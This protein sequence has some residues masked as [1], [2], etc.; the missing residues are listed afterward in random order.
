[1][2]KILIYSDHHAHPHKDGNE[3]LPSGRSSRLQD[4]LDVL[5]EIH[6]VALDQA[7][8]V[9]FGGDLFHTRKRVD[10]DAFN[11]VVKRVEDSA[12]YQPY[13]MLVGNH[14]QYTK[15][16]SIH[17]L[18]SFDGV[19][20]ID[21]PQRVHTHPDISVWGI[22]YSDDAKKVVREIEEGVQYLRKKGDFKILL[23][24]QGISGA[25]LTAADTVRL[26]TEMTL[27][28]LQPDKWDLVLSGHYHL[29]QKLADNVYHIGG[30]YQH[31]WAEANEDRGYW[32]L[33]IDNNFDWTMEHHSTKAPRFTT[34]VGGSVAEVQAGDFVRVVTDQPLTSHPQVDKL[35]KI[36]V[37]AELHYKPSTQSKQKRR[38]TID[39][40]MSQAEMVQSYLDEK[41]PPDLEEESLLR[42]GLGFLSGDDD[43]R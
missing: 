43:A 38:S 41:A 16:G 27:E 31:G 9:L 32:I 11:E 34:L 33:D 24:H 29:P 20:L 14:D 8:S 12:G 17:S 37:H 39:V 1:M 4:S 3:I 35:L 2:P 6:E 19:N 18:A 23:I 42:M 36:G 25:K 26:K 30:T 21:E 28:A 5:D 15:S 7:N 13:T 22:P 40:S 10:V